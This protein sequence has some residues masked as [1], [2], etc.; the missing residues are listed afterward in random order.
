MNITWTAAQYRDVWDQFYAQCDEETKITLDFRLDQ[1]IEK[2]CLCREPISKHL[3]G[4]I[5]E[6][7]AKNARALFYFG[8]ERKL[9]F[10]H[11]ITKKRSKVPRQDIEYAE[12]VMREIEEGKEAISGITNTN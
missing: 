1:L 7:R 8:P 9:V 3:D 12:K 10:V 6:L 5:F 11:A 4:K 2:G